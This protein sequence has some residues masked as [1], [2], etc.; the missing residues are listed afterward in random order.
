MAPR[1]M[2]T[3]CPARRK[4]HGDTGRPEPTRAL[5]APSSDSFTGAG[6]PPK[7]TMVNTLGVD[8]TLRRCSKPNRQKT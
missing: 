4:G 1:T 3:R 7:L 5:T 2:R 6:F 8:S